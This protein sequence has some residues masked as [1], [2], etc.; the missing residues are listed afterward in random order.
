MFNKTS[1]K[2]SSLAPLMALVLII[3]LAWACRLQTESLVKDPEPVKLIGGFGFTEGPAIDSEGRFYFTDIPNNKLYRW[4]PENGLELIRDHTGWGNGLS[5]NDN[6][7]LI[8]CEMA[9]RRLTKTKKGGEV[10]VFTDAYK[11]KKYNG[12]NDIWLHPGGSI[13]F[14]DPNYFLDESETELEVEAVY[15]IEPESGIVSRVTDHLVRPNGI[16]GTKDGN[17]LYVVS[18]TIHKTWKFKI[19][20]DG[21]LG[22]KELFV[23][24]GHD[25]LTLDAFGNLYIANRDNL[26]VDIYD[27]QG[28]YFQS[29][30]F[31]EQP[32]NVCFGGEENGKTLFVTAQTSVYTVA[33]KV[34]GQF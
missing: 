24:N 22:E 5:I 2:H 8:L 30:Q 6:G 15:R 4:T 33:M 28:R 10:V 16:I 11:G 32:S 26:S 34:K 18:D 21:S 23:N 1:G 3:I 31:P 19:E 13:Y 29:I 20:K 17:K 25:G 14:T 12:P 27:P 7:D 9:N